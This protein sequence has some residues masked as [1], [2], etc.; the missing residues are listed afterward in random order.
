MASRHLSAVLRICASSSKA[1]VC[2]TS[3]AAMEGLLD[4][5]F[6]VARFAL[7]GGNRP[8]LSATPGEQFMHWS[9]RGAFDIGIVEETIEGVMVRRTGGARTVVDLFRYSRYL[10]SEGE[11]L[12]LRAGSR[13]VRRGGDPADIL[14]TARELAIPSAAMAGLEKA[15]E[16]WNRIVR[17]R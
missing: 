11:R 13:L 6:P 14:E 5:S 12:G 9:A 8:P 10:M 17:R 7:P 3:A 1:V 16:T 2:L 15:T 4:G